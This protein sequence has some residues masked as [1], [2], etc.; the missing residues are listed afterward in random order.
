MLLHAPGLN[1]GHHGV[2]ARLREAL[3]LQNICEYVHLNTVVV[4]VVVVMIII[5]IKI[6]IIIITMILIMI[7]MIVIITAIT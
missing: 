7:L 6:M 2:Q 1:G 5:I 4:V 3:Q